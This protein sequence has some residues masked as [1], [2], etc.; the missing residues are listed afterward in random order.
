[1]IPGS[2]LHYPDPIVVFIR[3][4]QHSNIKTTADS[5]HQAFPQMTWKIAKIYLLKFFKNFLNVTKHFLNISK[6]PL[7]TSYIVLEINRFWIIWSKFSKFSKC[8][9]SIE[10]VEEEDS[11]PTMLPASAILENC[12]LSALSDVECIFK[13]GTSKLD[14]FLVQNWVLI[15][16]HWEE[17]I[18]LSQK[19]YIKGGL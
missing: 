15:Q 17:N 18:G 16:E 12:Y 14:F 1:M 5:S 9:C 6:H 8:S 11:G 13:C 10:V 7:N 3:R 4:C 2:L 19:S